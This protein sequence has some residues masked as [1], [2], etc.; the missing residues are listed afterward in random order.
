MDVTG[1]VTK[2]GEED[3][4]EEVT[5]AASDKGNRCWGEE[6]SNLN[7]NQSSVYQTGTI[8]KHTRMRR[9]SEPCTAIVRCEVE[10]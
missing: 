10:G 2:D 6:D 4:D 8:I 9:T 1:E 3:V 7:N 5:A